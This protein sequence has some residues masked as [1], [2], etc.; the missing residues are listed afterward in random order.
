MNPAEEWDRQV[1]VESKAATSTDARPGAWARCRR[2]DPRPAEAPRSGTLTFMPAIPR[3]KAAIDPGLRTYL[4]DLIAG[5]TPWPLYLFG[6][7]GRGKTCAAL[8][9]HD[10]AGG[11]YFGVPDLLD[12]FIRSQQGRA[13]YRSGGESRALHPEGL[14]Q[15]IVTARLVIMDELGTRTKVSD[16]HYDVV[17]GALDRR[18]GV[19]LVVIGN[20]DLA[21]VAGLY[22]GRI[23]SRLEAGTVVELDGPDR[24]IR[25][26]V[27]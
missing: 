25:G 2:L 22:D 26:D 1:Q 16:F 10:Y 6:K 4:R 9:L 13:T 24:R 8:C 14:W 3:S 27:S 23:A 11:M 5:L 15:A 19:P 21:G 18:E 7:P 12:L 17:K 20:L